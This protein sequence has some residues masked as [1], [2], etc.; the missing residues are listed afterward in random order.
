MPSKK[1]KTP[2]T[3]VTPAATPD[4]LAALARMTVP[5]L[6]PIE[7]LTAETFAALP[8]KKI[9]ALCNKADGRGGDALRARLAPLTNCASYLVC[10]GSLGVAARRSH[11]V[12]DPKLWISLS[13]AIFAYQLD[14]RYPKPFGIT[15]TGLDEAAPDAALRRAYPYVFFSLIERSPGY[16]MSGSAQPAASYMVTLTQHLLGK[17]AAAYDAWLDKLIVRLTAVATDP[18]PGASSSINDYPSREAWEAAV[19]VTHGRPL[20][21][22]LL[23]VSTELP[24]EKDW[25]ALVAAAF[26]RF[27][28]ETNPLL[29]PKA[30]LIEQGLPTPY[31]T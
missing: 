13:E 23:D 27:S 17:Q 3:T 2:A 24:P 30:A 16:F 25:P 19:R 8:K 31:A 11:T 14:W 20:P 9:S 22:E 5:G 29:Q 28:P 1:T 10:I 4:P 21:L 6:P 18:A 12:I 15:I 26:G 7:P